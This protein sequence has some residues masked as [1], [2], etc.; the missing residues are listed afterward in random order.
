[1]KCNSNSGIMG[2]WGRGTK[3]HIEERAMIIKQW[4][5]KT[6]REVVYLIFLIL[7]FIPL[8]S[9]F[10]KISHLGENTFKDFSFKECPH[11]M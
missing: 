4:L 11:P 9:S 5:Y 7:F 2:R 8:S 6:P 10:F 3:N 1:M